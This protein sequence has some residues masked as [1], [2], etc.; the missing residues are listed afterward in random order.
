V[1]GKTWGSPR[2]GY[3]AAARGATRAHGDALSLREEDLALG[4]LGAE[5]LP[6]MP[7]PNP[8]TRLGFRAPGD[9]RTT[10]L[11]APPRLGTVLRVDDRSYERRALVEARFAALAPPSA[12][13]SRRASVA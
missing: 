12:H 11:T 5:E 3:E 8:L 10:H 13:P 2:F 7:L 9:P 1:P 6:V 4:A